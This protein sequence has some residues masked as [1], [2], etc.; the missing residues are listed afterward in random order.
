METGEPGMLGMQPISGVDS[1]PCGHIDDDPDKGKGLVGIG[2]VVYIVKRIV[3][4][5]VT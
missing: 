3:R 4:I 2:F 5:T 1:L